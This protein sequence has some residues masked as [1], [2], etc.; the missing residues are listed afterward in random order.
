MQV[1]CLQTASESEGTE[2]NVRNRHLIGGR[3]FRKWRKGDD[4][5]AFEGTC[6]GANN[7]DEKAFSLNLVSVFLTFATPSEVFLFRCKP[8]VILT[9]NFWRIKSSCIVM[10]AIWSSVSLLLDQRRQ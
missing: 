8:K 2:L 10:Y 1:K 6:L 9:S 5:A 3:L 4:L 7:C